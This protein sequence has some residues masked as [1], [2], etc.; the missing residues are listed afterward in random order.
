MSRDKD[1][2]RGGRDGTVGGAP[3]SWG[4]RWCRGA[5]STQ[6]CAPTPGER[7]ARGKAARNEVPRSSMAV[8]CRL[9]SR[10]DPVGLLEEQAEVRVP[11]LVPIRYGRML[12]SPFTFYRAPR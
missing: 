2:Q 1:R 5:G 11:E 6:G 3:E 4:R 10:P 12:V 9:S 7:M 8:G